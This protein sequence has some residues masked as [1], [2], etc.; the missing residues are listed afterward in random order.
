MY[1]VA[2]SL[3]RRPAYQRKHI[4]AIAIQT[5]HRSENRANKHK[6]VLSLWMRLVVNLDQLFHGN[7]SVDLRS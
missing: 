2:F 4:A 1:V 6:T 7:M 3:L 5:A